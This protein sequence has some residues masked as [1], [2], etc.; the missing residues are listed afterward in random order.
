[1]SN[2]KDN[3]PC[4]F[5]VAITTNT[6]GKVTGQSYTRAIASADVAENAMDLTRVGKHSF[7]KYNGKIYRVTEQGKV[8]GPPIENEKFEKIKKVHEEYLEK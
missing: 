5:V 8:I 7:E 4:P 6:K 2:G 1:M 3:N